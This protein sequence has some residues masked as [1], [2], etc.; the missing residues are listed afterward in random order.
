MKSKII[1]N[2]MLVATMTACGP[3]RGNAN[4]ETHNKTVTVN[5]EAPDA[6]F[7][8]FTYKTRGKCYD[9]Y[10]VYFHFLSTFH[11]YLVLAPVADGRKM[12]ASLQVF[13]NEDGIYQA[14]YSELLEVRVR[15]DENRKYHVLNTIRIGGSASLNDEGEMVLEGLGRLRALKYNDKPAVMLHVEKNIHTPG[16]TGQKV[17]M[18]MVTSTAGREE[19]KKVCPGY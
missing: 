17:T 6:Y 11:D 8:R 10:G 5:G 3:S 19:Y 4:N 12:E 16:I 1:L 15:P 13:L 7:K 14:D 9:Q 18:V 2:L